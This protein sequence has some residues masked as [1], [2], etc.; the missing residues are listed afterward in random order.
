MD[1]HHDAQLRNERS[2]T[3][4]GDDP[5]LT[6]GIALPCAGRAGGAQGTVQVTYQEAGGGTDVTVEFE[7]DLPGGLFAG[8]A[9]KLLGG[10][11]ERDLRHSM[12][13]FKELAEATVPAHA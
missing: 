9:E 5:V 1:R 4:S 13:N 2:E 6:T 10:S 3:A 12:E 8:I 7:Y 11:I